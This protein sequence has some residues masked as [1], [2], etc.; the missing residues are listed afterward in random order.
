VLS[1]STNISNGVA[2]TTLEC[3]F[4]AHASKDQTLT[5]AVPI[6]APGDVVETA[7]ASP[8]SEPIEVV[9]PSEISATKG[10]LESK[11]LTADLQLNLA[12]TIAD[13]FAAFQSAAFDSGEE[14]WPMN[15]PP[16]G[17][18]RLRVGRVVLRYYI[19]KGFDPLVEWVDIHHDENNPDGQVQLKLK[20]DD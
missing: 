18:D 4:G 5:S 1:V 2:S 16:M 9:L 6:G 8:D 12:K 10:N 19:N 7:V 15:P 11:L 14:P 20:G 13:H 17:V 3:S